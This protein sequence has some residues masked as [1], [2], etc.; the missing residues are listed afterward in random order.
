[1]TR[2]RRV[3]RL[4]RTR[5]RF[6]SRRRS[7]TTT[8][9]ARSRTDGAWAAGRARRWARTMNWS[10]TSAGRATTGAGRMARRSA[11][12]GTSA[13][14]TSRCARRRGR[15]LLNPSPPSRMR[16]RSSRPRSRSWSLGRSGRRVRHQ[17]TWRSSRR[18]S[19]WVTRV[20]RG[21]IPCKKK[22]EERRRGAGA[23]VEKGGFRRN[24]CE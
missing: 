19:R 15:R 13:C 1:M 24:R 2:R 16:N 14:R 20:D 6:M 11:R 23:L 5:T 12:R 3:R 21:L 22:N 10:G 9:A 8:A 17:M 4:V 7:P 18:A